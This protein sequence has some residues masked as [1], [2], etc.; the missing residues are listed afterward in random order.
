M[1]E[2]HLAHINFLFLQT[3]G[4]FKA[5]GRFKTM[6]LCLSEECLEPRGRKETAKNK[7]DEDSLCTNTSYEASVIN[8]ELK[9]KQRKLW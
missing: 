8:K 2:S 1:F 5:L 9:V 7:G 4:E 3:K 6:A